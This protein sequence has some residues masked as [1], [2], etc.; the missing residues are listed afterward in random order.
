MIQQTQQLFLL[1]VRSFTPKF[2]KPRMFNAAA[3]C[4][5]LE[6]QKKCSSPQRGSITRNGY[7]MSVTVMCISVLTHFEIKSQN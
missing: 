7:N 1:S 4:K 3:S 6:R 2:L 5:C